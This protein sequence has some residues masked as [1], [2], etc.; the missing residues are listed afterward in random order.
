MIQN[1]IIHQA[2]LNEVKKLV[3][4]AC[5]DV[6]SKNC[7]QPMKEEFLLTTGAFESTCEPFAVAKLAGIK[8]CESYNR[9]YGTDFIVVI[10]PNV[11]GSNQHYDVMNSQVLPALIKKFHEAKVSGKGKVIIWGSGNPKR[12]SFL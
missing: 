6:Y 8:M 7:Q 1:N 2:F 12:I 4:L 5:A 3:F 10:P 9:Q 11:Y